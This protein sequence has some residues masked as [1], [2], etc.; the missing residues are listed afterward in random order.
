LFYFSYNNIK[1]KYY[2]TLIIL[3]IIIIDS[4][5]LY[6]FLTPILKFGESKISS[7]PIELI[8]ATLYKSNNIVTLLL[9]LLFSLISAFIYIIIGML[10][11]LT[12]AL[13]N[14]AIKKLYRSLLLIVFVNLGCNIIY[15]SI[16]TLFYFIFG[17]SITIN[18]WFILTYSGAIYIFGNAS[19]VLI[20]CINSTE[21]RE[22][23]LE[24]FILIKSFFKRTFCNTVNPQSNINNN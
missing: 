2:I 18:I 6:F 17:T 21:Y 3:N 12:T 20:L 1:T 15:F 9:P 14:E 13:N 5:V 4:I 8:L 19:S 7:N 11:K 10:T 23:Y 22:A 16:C 24:E